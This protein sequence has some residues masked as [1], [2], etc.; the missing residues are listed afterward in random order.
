MVIDMTNEL[1]IVEQNSPYAI[2]PVLDMAAAKVRRQT[3]IEYTRQMMVAGRDFGVVPGTGDK[4][5][6]LK[7]G[8]EKLASLFGLSPLFELMEREMDWTGERHD[9]EPFFYMQYLSLKHI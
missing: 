2:M 8:A 3:V 6:L 4:P 5:T 1:I 9:G 7:P